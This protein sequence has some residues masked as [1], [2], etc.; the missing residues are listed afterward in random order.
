MAMTHLTR[1]LAALALLPL[2]CLAGTVSVTVTDK[3]GKPV[4][5]AVVV[6]LTKNPGQPKEALPQQTTITQFKMQFQPQVSVVPVGSKLSFMNNDTWEHHVRGSAAGMAQFAAGTA[7]GFE[8]RLDGKAE[9]RPASAASITVDKPGAMLLGCHLHSS[10]RGH[11]YVSDSPWALK[12]NADGVAQFT[13]VPDGAA[14]VRVWQADQLLDLAPLNITVG[15]TPS[16]SNVQLQVVPRR[17]R[18]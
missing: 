2:T 12:T 5:D 7:G 16:Q 9:G 3:E 18:I 6:V 8:L 1:L 15:A 17:R 13:D 10:M 4:P 14:Q 11:V